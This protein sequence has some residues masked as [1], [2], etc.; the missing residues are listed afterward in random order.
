[1]FWDNTKKI[2]SW[3]PEKFLKFL[4]SLNFWDNAKKLVLELLIFTELFLNF[5][6]IL[7]MQTVTFWCAS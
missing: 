5:F 4:I 6:G 1:M 7:E 2:D 3:T